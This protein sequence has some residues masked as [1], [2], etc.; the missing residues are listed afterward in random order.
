MNENLPALKQLDS[1]M[2]KADATIKTLSTIVEKEY[3]SELANLPVKNFEAPSPEIIAE[4]LWLY[5]IDMLAYDKGDD[6]FSKK[7]EAVVSA[8]NLCGGTFT[9]MIDSGVNETSLFMGVYADESNSGIDTLRDVLRDSL[10]GNF[11]GIKIQD[12]G[13]NL[14]ATK[15]NIIEHFNNS[16]KNQCVTAIS[17]IAS[18]SD[19]NIFSGIDTILNSVEGQVFTIL[20]MAKPV[21]KKLERQTRDAYEKISTQISQ[22]LNMSVGRQLSNTVSQNWQDTEGTS[23]AF[24]TGTSHSEGSGESEDTTDEDKSLVKYLLDAGAAFTALSGNLPVA[25]GIK[26]AGD[27]LDVNNKQPRTSQSRNTQDSINE[28]RTDSDLKQHSRGESTGTTTGETFQYNVINRS[29]KRL[30]ENIERYLEWLNSVKM[31]GLMNVSTYIISPSRSLNINIASRYNAILGGPG[32]HMYGVN[33]WIGNDADNIKQYLM[34]G[35]HPVL[36]HNVFGEVSPAVL[37]SAHELVMHLALPQETVEGITVGKHAAFGRNVIY[38]IDTPESRKIPLGNVFHMGADKTENAV[39][40]SF[41]DLVSHCLIGGA[42]GIGKT[43]AICSV[44]SS[45]HENGIPFLVIEPAKGEY[46]HAL[47]GVQ[48]IRIYSPLPVEQK[49]DALKLNLFWFRDG[50]DPCEHIEKLK[51][52]FCSCWPMYAAMP[53]VLDKA[54]YNAY[55]KCGWNLRTQKNPWGKIFPSLK[56]V[57]NEVKNAIAQADFSAEVKGNYIG[58]LLSRLE[59]LGHGM[60]EQVFSGGNL[61][62]E[63]IFEHSVIIDLSRPDASEFKALVTG[64][65]IMRL[66]EY[67]TSSCEI[68]TERTLK[69]VTVLEEAHNLLKQVKATSEGA[70]IREKSL[71]MFTRCIT[72]LGGWGRGFI[73]SDQSPGIL[74]EDVI[75]NTNTKLLFNLPHKI[76]YITCGDSL[77]L[78][79]AQKEEIPQLGRGVCVV[80]QNSWEEPVLCHV[81]KNILSSE[82]NFEAHYSRLDGVKEYLSCLLKFYSVIG[83]NKPAVTDDELSK[84]LSWANNSNFSI[85]DRRKLIDALKDKK[86][87]KLCSEIVGMIVNK[88]EL[89]LYAPDRSNIEQWT[90]KLLTAISEE[91]TDDY[92]IGLTV[93]EALLS[94]EASDDFRDLWFDAMSPRRKFVIS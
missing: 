58:S 4:N 50:V 83:K 30:Y 3:Y 72:E 22:L 1:V 26:M 21:N 69:H 85:E 42:S 14:E 67:C 51:E 25:Y 65:I 77:G 64:V 39:R 16:Y 78:S 44:L 80:K 86:S 60:S 28:S 6:D 84:A 20:V 70:D 24:Q 93:I 68:M 27:I 48:D 49:T 62:D 75:K 34:A 88:D 54:L 82:K 33:T 81:H 9:V 56:D 29:A 61:T 31:L 41:N 36:L 74:C 7:F 87:W 52:I 59:S 94:G 73:I 2:I 71:E 45:L 92:L 15:N 57:C 35:R 8:V 47:A 43:T 5:K 17:S 91:Y 76:D 90:E 37:M 79:D 19:D 55:Q 46:K 11:Q 63:E 66:F 13:E 53:Q 38:K 18:A 23:R 10:R 89:M 32:G 40:L 12:I